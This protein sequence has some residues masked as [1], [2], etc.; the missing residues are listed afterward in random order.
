MGHQSYHYLK[1]K[2][3]TYRFSRRVPR[4][5]QT[6]SKTTRVEICLFTSVRTAAVLQAVSLSQDLE[7][8]WSILRRRQRNDR[9]AGLFGSALSV[10]P[11]RIIDTVYGPLVS[12]VLETYVRLK[13]ARR[14]DTFEAGARRSVVYLLEVTSDK[15]IDTPVRQDDNALREYLKSRGLAKDSIARNSTYIRAIVNLALREHGLPTSTA[16]IGVCLGETIAP[17]KRYVPTSEELLTLIDLCRHQDDDLLWILALIA[18]TGLRLSEA[19]GLHKTDVVLESDTPHILIC[20]HPWRRLKTPSSER[21]VP[22][23]GSAHWASQRAIQATT[24]DF[25]FP[26]YARDD[27]ILSNSA[28]AALNKWLKSQVNEAMVIHSLRH[29]MRDRLGDVE[30]PAEIIDTI[31]GW[32]REGVG[33]TYGREYYLDVLSK[34]LERASTHHL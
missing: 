20:P 24:N 8:H 32:A 31:G 34:W 14:S 27:R 5:L 4:C 15:A 9:I 28:C 10:E 18:D 16:F 3:S 25:L 23:V 13:G 11:M 17:K 6:L 30:C 12:E 33:E 26:R 19:L 7:D 21:V 1:L 29:S 22:L 2:G